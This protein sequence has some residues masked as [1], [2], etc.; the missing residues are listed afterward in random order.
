MAISMH[1]IE[2]GCG[3]HVRVAGYRKLF[4]SIH[5]FE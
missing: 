1:E 3:N 5:P 2:I 4:R